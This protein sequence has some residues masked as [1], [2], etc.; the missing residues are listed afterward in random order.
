MMGIV[1][2]I[3][4]VAIQIF[5]AV[6]FSAIAQMK[7]HQGSAYFWWSFLCGPTGWI[8]V[9]ALPDRADKQEQTQ[10]FNNNEL[11]YL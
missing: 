2:L 5:S 6:Q 1:I 10:N 3:I 4:W 9:A 8:M 11:P 7:G